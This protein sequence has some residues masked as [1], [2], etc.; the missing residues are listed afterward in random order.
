MATTLRPLFGAPGA[1]TSPLLPT[2]QDDSSRLNRILRER[3]SFELREE[4]IGASAATNAAAAAAAA[5]ARDLAAGARLSAVPAPP[6]GAAEAAAAEEMREWKVCFVLL[7]KAVEKENG[8]SRESGDVDDDDG[9]IKKQGR[10]RQKKR[11]HPLFSLSLSLFSTPPHYQ[12]LKYPNLL[13]R[14]DAF[15]ASLRGKRLALFLDYDG[16]LTPIVRDP[17]R[18]FLSDA[19]RAAVRAA[20]AAFPAAIVSGRGRE[21]VEQFVK[22]P[23]LYYAGSHGMDI[24]GPAVVAESGGG[25]EEGEDCGDEAAGGPPTSAEEGGDGSSSPPTPT[26]T[27]TRGI[28]FRPAAEFA[29]VMDALHASLVESLVGI[30]GSSVEHNTFCVSVSFFFFFSPSFWRFSSFL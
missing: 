9:E 18:A 19:T 11:P 26:T 8:I 20:A 15:V 23:E 5:L 27:T 21:K 17:D 28:A 13:E 29:P 10:R 6:L 16:T 12:Q 30:P 2:A 3:A 22:L 14:F 4:D 24:V 7:V 25:R 1:T